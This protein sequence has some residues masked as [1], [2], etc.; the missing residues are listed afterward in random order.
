MVSLTNRIYEY[1]IAQLSAIAL[2]FCVALF[3]T[4][5]CVL[6]VRRARSRRSRSRTR[7]A[8]GSRAHWRRLET[9][10]P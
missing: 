10:E 4:I 3:G 7:S 2:G 9:H 1:L 6:L 8:G 5:V